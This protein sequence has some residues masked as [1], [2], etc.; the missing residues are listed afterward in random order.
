M[1]TN[2]ANGTLDLGRLTTVKLYI[3]STSPFARVARI[4]VIEKG[5]SDQVEIVEARTRTTG[6]PFYELNPSGRVPFLVRD[7]GA[8][9]ED[10]QLIGAYLDS[11][12]G[13]PV[14]TPSL[15]H[16][17]WEYGRLEAYARSM[18]DGLSVWVREMRRPESE[19]SPT[20]IAHEAARADRLADF[21]EREISNPLMQGPLNLAQLYLL[22]GLDQVA[23]WKLGDYSQGRPNLA[24]WRSRLHQHP[25]IKATAPAR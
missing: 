4:V 12:D 18:T 11:L 10:S 24:A 5:L 15:S 21:W 22:A 2:F 6:S 9:I 8:A 1:L 13:R 19:R 3:T 23:F 17:A 20:V 25:S 7:D 14:L 16:D